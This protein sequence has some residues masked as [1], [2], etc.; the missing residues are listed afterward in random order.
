M[1]DSWGPKGEFFGTGFDIKVQQKAMSRKPI[2][3]PRFSHD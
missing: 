2:G 3:I 1:G